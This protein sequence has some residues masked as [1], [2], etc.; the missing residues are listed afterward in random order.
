M[1]KKFLCYYR[2]SLLTMLGRES[3]NYFLF[4]GHFRPGK[5][6]TFL[7]CLG[8]ECSSSLKSQT[9]LEEIMVNVMSAVLFFFTINNQT[10]KENL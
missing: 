2:R 10:L 5:D 6:T 7:Y 4:L 1:Y 9:H 8:L 3:L